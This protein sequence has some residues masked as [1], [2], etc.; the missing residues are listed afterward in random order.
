MKVLHIVPTYFP[1]HGIGGP[2][3][4]VHLLNKWLVKRGVEVT[5]FT[6]NFGIKEAIPLGKEVVLDGVKVWYFPVSLKF[7]QYSSEMRKAIKNT[8]KNFDIAH[9]TSV[10]LGA[11]TLGAYYARKHKKPY[12][13]SP[14]GSLMKE[15][16]GHRKIKKLLYLW[17][18]EKR[19]L[20]NASAIHFTLPVERDEYLELRLPC[21]K[22]IVVPNG[23][24]AGQMA[25][26]KGQIAGEEF[27]RKYGIKEDAKV[28][29]FLGRISWKKGFDTLMPAFKRAKEQIA[30]SEWQM[31]KNEEQRVGGKV[32]LVIAGPDDE[33]YKSEVFKQIAKN[34]LRAGEDVIFTGMLIGEEK[35][36]AFDVADVFALPSYAENFGIAVLEAMQ[37]GV[38]VVATFQV[39]IAPYIKEAN[40]GVV[41]EKNET[42]V[43]DAICK[44]LSNKEVAY[45]MAKNGTLLAKKFSA[46]TVANDM[47]AQYEGLLR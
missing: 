39:G 44:I 2:I 11:S 40:A 28:V 45:D 30:N 9:I 41:V 36:V 31:A 24:E 20:E 3:V 34:K 26:S 14:R 29:L 1:A 35:K 46:E 15:T 17:L 23:I 22:A 18:I 33:G 27:K 37:A 38:P 43:A 4:S 6:T 10:F 25:N 13:I 16:I 32:V 21:K 7:W 5:V 12:V 19:N 47:L 8:L 42:D